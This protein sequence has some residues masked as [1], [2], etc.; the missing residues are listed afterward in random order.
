MK[1]VFL[2][3]KKT[4]QFIFRSSC[5]TLHLIPSNRILFLTV[6]AQN[7]QQLCPTFLYTVLFSHTKIRHIEVNAKCPYLK[8]LTCKVTLW[9]VFIRFYR[10]EIASNLLRIFSHVGIFNPALWSV[11]PFPFSLVQLPPLP[12]SLCE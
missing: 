3:C 7:Y 6:H 12:P 1:K 4:C 11:A 2:F 9:K 5:K 10:L 8:K